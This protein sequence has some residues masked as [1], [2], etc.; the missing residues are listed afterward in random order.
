[1]T[2]IVL[3]TPSITSS[4]ESDP[5]SADT[6]YNIGSPS[7]GKTILVYLKNT[8]KYTDN[9]IAE[10]LQFSIPLSMP[11]FDATITKRFRDHFRGSCYP[12]GCWLHEVNPHKPLII[13]R[14]SENEKD[15]PYWI[16]RGD[17]LKKAK[18]RSTTAETNASSAR[19]NNRIR[20]GYISTLLRSSQECLLYVIAH[21]LRHLYQAKN[22]VDWVYG[23]RGRKSSERDADAYAISKVREWRRKN[24]TKEAEQAFHAA[25]LL[26]FKFFRRRIA[27]LLDIM[28]NRRPIIEL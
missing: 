23:S 21:E 25:S 1:M 8:T 11:D 20:H 22:K 13:V 15:F 28:L 26:L 27:T 17:N 12:S 2:N 4:T 24:M 9:E 14:T 6:I 19:K 3:W 10:I 7:A 5:A 16:E 18:R